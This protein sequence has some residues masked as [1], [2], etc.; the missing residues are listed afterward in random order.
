MKHTSK[1]S[2]ALAIGLAPAIGGLGLR[3]SAKAQGLVLKK[4]NS[5][6]QPRT[7]ATDKFADH[8]N[9]GGTVACR[10]RLCTDDITR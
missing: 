7:A 10:A 9:G 8:T 4:A 2:F 1:T 6:V 3:S 5:H